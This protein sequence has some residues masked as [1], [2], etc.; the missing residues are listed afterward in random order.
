MAW[1]FQ[2][3]TTLVVLGMCMCVKLFICPKTQQT[4]LLVG[5]ED[6]CIRLFD[7]GSGKIYSFVK[8]HSE[9]GNSFVLNKNGRDWQY[10]PRIILL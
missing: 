2:V 8:V 4:K 9:S 1:L 10:L 5:Y 3:I 7:V 6:G